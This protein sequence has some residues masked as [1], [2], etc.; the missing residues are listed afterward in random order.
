M[1]ASAAYAGARHGSSSVAR[2]AAAS[3]SREAFTFSGPERKV[4]RF[5]RLAARQ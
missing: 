4:M 2:S 5:A 1:I 3:I